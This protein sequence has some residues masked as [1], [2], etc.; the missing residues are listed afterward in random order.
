MRFGMA[1]T[2]SLS[3]SSSVDKPFRA[4]RDIKRPSGVAADLNIH[5]AAAAMMGGNGASDISLLPRKIEARDD[6]AQRIKFEP[7]F[8]DIF[9]FFGCN[10]FAIRISVVIRS[11]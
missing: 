6:P 2:V 1:A 8:S 4:V 11:Q 3:S 9:V 5:V 10:P 7:Y